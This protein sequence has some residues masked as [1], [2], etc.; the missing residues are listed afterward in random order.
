MQISYFYAFSDVVIF[1]TN[2]D[3]RLRGD[4]WRLMEWVAAAVSKSVNHLAHKTLII[5]LNITLSINTKLY[6]ETFLKN[7]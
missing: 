1:V 6:D 2:E 5:I 4:L 7:T 3:Q